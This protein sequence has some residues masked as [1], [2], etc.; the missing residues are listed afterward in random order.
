MELHLLSPILQAGAFGVCGLLIWL[1]WFVV[2]KFLV[3][4]RG[5]TTALQRLIGLVDDTRETSREVRDRLLEWECPFR[6]GTGKPR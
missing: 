4:F 5:N 1:V 6:E 3:A 2:S